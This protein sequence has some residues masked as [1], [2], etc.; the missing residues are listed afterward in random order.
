MHRG[1]RVEHREGLGR[2]AKERTSTIVVRCLT[3]DQLQCFEPI[4]KA[5]GTMRFKDQAFSHMAHRR[6]G[7]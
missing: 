2:Q 1:E 6:V 7:R 4:D 3:R 5:G